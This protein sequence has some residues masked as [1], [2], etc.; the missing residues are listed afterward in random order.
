M[1]GVSG[2]MPKHSELLDDNSIKVL[3]AYVYS[4]T[5]E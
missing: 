3:A 5:N 1:D 4:L 2:K